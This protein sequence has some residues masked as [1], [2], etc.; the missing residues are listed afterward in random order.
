MA[1][2]GMAAERP[3]RSLIPARLDRLPWA[4]FHWLVVL[5]LGVSWILDG[6]EIQLVSASG[7]KESLGMTSEDVG[8][9]GTIYLVGQVVG[10][11]VFGRLTDRW[12]RKKLFILTLA[13]YLVGSGVAGLAWTPWFLYLFRFVAGLGIGGEYTAI[14]SAIDELI[15]AKYRG[16]VD[17]AV[18]GTYWAGAMIGAVASF[19]LLNHALLPENLGWRLAFFVGPILG[20]VIIYLRRHIPESPRWMLTHGQAAEAERIVDGIEAD[21]EAKGVTLPQVD[22]T[23]AM[24]VQPEKSVPFSKLVDVF[25]RQYPSRTFLGI[26]MMITQSFLYNAIFFTYAL[27]LQNFYGLNASQASLYFFPFAIGN[28]LGPLLLGPLFDTIGR[29]RMIFATYGAGGRG[30]ARLGLPVQDRHVD[31]ADPHDALVRVVLFRIRGRLLGLSDGQRDLPARGP[32][33]GH[34]LLLRRQPGRRRHGTADLRP[35]RRRR[36]RAGPALLGLCRRCRGDDLRRPRR[37]VLRRRC[38]RAR[39]RRHCRP[40]HQS[41]GRVCAV[42]RIG[43]HLPRFGE[44]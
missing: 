14:N 6:I 8:F 26:T 40:A 22:E 11:L 9:T 2:S 4:Q 25:F 35:P 43:R 1:S 3:V 37:P 42:I 27:V 34:L 7:F 16:R 18:N 29:R 13:I 28:L 12:G 17:I 36:N 23:R 31:G 38:G 19:F 20:L 21:V 30:P 24:T 5:G 39:S 32:R 41:Q 15:P 33:P 44:G 10:A